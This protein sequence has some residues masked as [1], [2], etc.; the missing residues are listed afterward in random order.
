[1]TSKSKHK[2]IRH[3][4]EAQVEKAPGAIAVACAGS[5]LTYQ[6]LNQQANQVARYLSTRGIEGT[7]TVG[8]C[9]EYSIELVVG[10]IGILKAGGTCVLLDPSHPQEWQERRL[11]DTHTQVLL[12]KEQ[13]LTQLPRYQGMAVCLDSEAGSITQESRENGAETDASSVTFLIGAASRYVMLEQQ[14]LRYHIRWLQK[15]F[16]LSPADTLLSLSSPTE[17]SI[18]FDIVW[19]LTAGSCL[20]IAP[21]GKICGMA[22][23]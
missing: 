21:G 22:S 7:T 18:L 6:E 8:L 20:L 14:Q 23:E 3:L 5:R 1:M 19:A 17:G 4:F 10:L 15:R 9:L 2:E 13:W 11:Q 16:A 12:T